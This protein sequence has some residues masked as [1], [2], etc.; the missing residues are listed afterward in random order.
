[1]AWPQTSQHLSWSRM[2]AILPVGSDKSL[3]PLEYR[4][5]ATD[6]STR[7]ALHEESR[8]AHVGGSDRELTG[9][10]W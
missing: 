5:D 8:R 4:G 6:G 9:A 10:S 3:E 2:L 1:M 7:S